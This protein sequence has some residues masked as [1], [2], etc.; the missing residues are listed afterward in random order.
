MHAWGTDQER[1]NPGPT[2]ASDLAMR[3]KIGSGPPAK[4]PGGQVPG[5]GPVGVSRGGRQKRIFTLMTD[6]DRLATVLAGRN[7]LERELGAGGMATVSLAEDLKHHR[8]P[9][10][11]PS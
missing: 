4:V 8:H 3:A 2:G 1:P 6:I 7:V 5:Q 9:H 11:S 10:S